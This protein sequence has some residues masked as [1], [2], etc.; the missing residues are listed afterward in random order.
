VELH[1]ARIHVGM[2][3]A[4]RAH[5]AQHFAP[6]GERGRRRVAAD[7]VVTDHLGGD[8]HEVA[9]R[10][11]EVE[12]ALDVVLSDLADLAG[13]E[14]RERA[15]LLEAKR[16]GGLLGPET[17]PAGQHHGQRQAQAGEFAFQY[18]VQCTH[19][20]PPCAGTL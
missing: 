7:R 3:P 16:D 11:L 14:V 5:A 6:P 15:E 1:L 17:L 12:A 13:G 4:A 20:Q 10:A 19:A 2:V 9:Q 18:G 8:R